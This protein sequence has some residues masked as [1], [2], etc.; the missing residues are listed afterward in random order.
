MKIIEK[1]ITIKLIDKLTSYK[2]VI[3]PSINP[4]IINIGMVETNIITASL[5]FIVNDFFLDKVPGNIKPFPNI[6]PHAPA[7]IITD[8]SIVRGHCFA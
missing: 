2:R 3:K 5:A 6:K 8:I 4:A 1:P 7:I